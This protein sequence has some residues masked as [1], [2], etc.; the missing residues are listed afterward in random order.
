MNCPFCNSE[1]KQNENYC[2]K[3]GK[4]IPRCPKCGTVIN[5]KIKFCPLDGTK[6]PE[7]ILQSFNS[8]KDYINNKTNE[9]VLIKNKYEKSINN[10]EKINTYKH[11]NIIIIIICVAIVTLISIG[12][13]YFYLSKSFIHKEDT[14]TTYENDIDSVEDTDKNEYKE[15]N[16]SEENSTENN[17]ES[18]NT[19]Q[20]KSVTQDM[21]SY[22]TET[23]SYTE[24][25]NNNN[26]EYLGKNVIDSDSTTAWIEGKNG[27]GI[28]ES[29]TINFKENCLVKGF[30][31]LNG[32]QKTEDLYEKNSRPYIVELKFSDGTSEVIYLSDAFGEQTIYLENPKETSYIT[33][34]IKDIYTGSQYMDTAISEISCF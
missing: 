1:I 25:L 26:I 14:N 17:S 33:W 6:I 9:D 22:V 20:V 21:I 18:E 4:K 19:T 10:N 24:V 5:K 32:F 8:N 30:N 16:V 11:K 3:C 27:Y 7:E 13:G 34:T 31:I 29:I 23:S 12:V 2:K 28:G 15:N